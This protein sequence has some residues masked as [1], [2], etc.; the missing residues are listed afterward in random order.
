MYTYDTR[1]AGAA[2]EAGLL[3]HAPMA[4]QPAGSDAVKDHTHTG[5]IE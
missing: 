1:M 4:D 2:S 5:Q 3:V